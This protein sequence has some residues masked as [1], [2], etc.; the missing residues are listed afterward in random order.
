MKNKILEDQIN[1]YLLGNLLPEDKAIFE[2]H[3]QQNPAFKKEVELQ[4]EIAKALQYKKTL[5]TKTAVKSFVQNWQQYV[6]ELNETK[7]NF[8]ETTQQK[9]ENVVED[10]SKLVLQIFNPYSAAFR[11]NAVEQLS[12][13]EQ[14]FFY[15]NSK[16]YAKA[17]PLLSQ[18]PK[19][20]QE[21]VLMLGNA[22][23][24]LQDYETA[25]TYFKQLI[26]EEAVF[27]LSDAHWYAGLCLTGLNRVAEAQ[28]H[29]LHLFNDENTNIELQQN[30]ENL[31]DKLTHLK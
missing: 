22:Y 12:T 24:A 17:I 28:T 27:F 20:D 14:A 18:L 30:A 11:S 16:D 21:V 13:E 4:Q 10:L 6:P 7:P 26:D 15:Y 3:M 1:L 8:I 23:L 2:E 19:E 25:Y 5:E 29:F 31:L 9:I